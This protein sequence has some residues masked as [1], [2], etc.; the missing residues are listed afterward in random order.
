MWGKERKVEV[1]W[2]EQPQFFHSNAAVLLE[3]PYTWNC[4]SSVRQASI[5]KP[6]RRALGKMWLPWRDVRCKTVLH[7]QQ[8]A[9]SPGSLPTQQCWQQ[10]WHGVSWAL[11]HC[12]APGSPAQLPA[13]TYHRFQ[14][15]HCCSH[16][17]QKKV[18]KVL[19]FLPCFMQHVHYALTKLWHYT[20]CAVLPQHHAFQVCA[21]G[22]TGAAC[23]PSNH[24]FE[25]TFLRAQTH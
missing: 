23:H 1:S 19:S 16:R 22:T 15:C 17:E 2:A 3:L 25:H 14:Q 4:T 24:S 10:P 9:G 13:A 7:L 18:L 5:N 8:G 20:W 12:S 21:L 11:W 6:Q